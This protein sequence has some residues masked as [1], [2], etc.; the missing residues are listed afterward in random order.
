MDFVEPIKSKRAIA[1]I[2]AVICATPFK[3]YDRNATIATPV[4]PQDARNLLYFT[5][6]INTPLSPNE[7]LSL[8]VGDVWDQRSDSPR[9][10]IDMGKGRNSNSIPLSKS[11]RGAINEFMTLHCGADA[12]QHLFYSQKDVTRPI[13]R[14][15]G[16]RLIKSW[17]RKA[18]VD[19]DYGTHSLRKTWG[20]W[21]WKSTGNIHMVQVLL[22]H[23]NPTATCAYL[24]I[25]WDELADETRQREVD[26]LYLGGLSQ[27][28]R[29]VVDCI[30][31]IDEA[32]QRS[33]NAVREK[34]GGAYSPFRD[35]MIG[36]FQ[37]YQ[38]SK[39]WSDNSSTALESA[40]QTCTRCGSPA[41]VAHHESYENWA[42]GQA[43]LQDL[44]PLCRNCHK[45]VHQEE[46]SLAT[47]FWAQAKHRGFV[48]QNL[49]LEQAAKDVSL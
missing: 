33:S 44:K 22:G 25:D 40:S 20:Y 19:G 42:F 38:R 2:K 3:P 46:D 36:V 47:P 8:R 10:S 31:K 30:R 24:A 23:G 14:T 28:A 48:A 27:G 49:V 41:R 29:N 12:S 16:Y 18:G 17:C 6:G 43:E 4:R 39:D 45:V 13:S 7:L 9:P 34:E 1:R 15:Q 32:M 11:A 37:M 35:A 5:L 21:V 26:S